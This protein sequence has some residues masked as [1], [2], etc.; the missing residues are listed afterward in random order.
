MNLWIE[1]KNGKIMDEDIEKKIGEREKEKEEKYEKNEKE[2][3]EKID[4]LKREVDDE[5]KKVKEKKLI[6]FN[7]EYKYLENRL[8]MKEEG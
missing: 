5:M 7:D 8:G 2:Y 6:V 1:K 4:E 3:G